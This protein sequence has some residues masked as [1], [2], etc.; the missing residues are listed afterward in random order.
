[1]R[2]KYY[3]F[4]GLLAFLLFQ[5]ILTQG[6]ISFNLKVGPQADGS[7]LVPSNQMLR[8]AGVQVSLPGRPVDLSLI[9]NGNFILVKN[10]KSLDLIR[11]KDKT[12]MQSL[13]YEK[14]SSSFTGIC[15]TSDN[16]HIYLSEAANK[17]LIAR[18][19]QSNRLSWET[20]IVIPAP[21]IGGDPGPGGLALNAREDRLFV[22]LSRSNSLA[23]VNLEDKSVKEIPVG[24][25]P[26]GVVLASDTK[27]YVTN[28]GGRRPVTGEST[29]NSSG[30][31]VLVDPNTGIANNG[32]VSVIDL[33]QNKSIK[34]IKVGLHP[35]GMV[36]S[37][38]R[39]LLYVACANS[40]V[41]DII[42]TRKDEKIGEIPVHAT[43]ETLFGS[44][45]NALAI[46]PDGKYLYVANGTENAIC[47]IE[48]GSENQVAG[49]IP[50]G[51][52]PGSVVISKTG[53][54]LYV[55]NVKGTG[56]RN[57]GAGR[58][59]FNS[60]D[61]LGSVSIIPVPDKATL[62]KMTDIVSQNN[63]LA[64][65]LK[66]QSLSGGNLKQVALPQFPG[67]ACSCHPHFHFDRLA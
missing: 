32:S 65:T 44:A 27:A 67:L 38:N 6:Q 46:S 62:P 48:T 35:S 4:R 25:C 5:S 56:A 31:Q 22:T 29:Y 1:M 40:D 15:L 45:P 66:D 50:T 10:I 43:N 8:P 60:H 9:S 49:R 3:S 55:A 59:G 13:P 37:P 36:L 57:K 42:D 54:E 30:S 17:I 7:V 28:W 11:L 26:Y 61:H 24:I 2:P 53:N 58:G 16:R 64:K 19:D 18:F 14:C 12:L 23:V 41:I 51:W 63:S 33:K 39:S 20:C 47:V 34:E 21:A 52:Y